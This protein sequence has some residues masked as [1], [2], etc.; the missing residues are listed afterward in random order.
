MAVVKSSNINI[1]DLDFDSVEASLKEYLKGQSTLKDY[2]FEGSNISVLIDLLAYSSHI[3]AFNANMVASEMFL[4]TAQIRKNVV[5]RAKEIG[6]T[7]S[8]KTASKATFDLTVNSPTIAGQTPSTLTI[9]RG[10]RFNTVYDGVTYTFISLDNKTITPDGGQ[11]KFS[12]L[13]VHQGSLTSDIYVYDSQESNQRFSLLNPNVDTSTISVSVNSNNIVTSWT[14]AADLVNVTSS[15]RNYFLQESDEGLYQI[16]FGDGIL[17]AQPKDGDTITISYLVVDSVYANGASTFSMLDSINGNSDVSF[18]NTI[19]SSGGKDGESIDSIKFSANKFYTSQNRL[20]TVADFKA[21]LQELYPGADSIAVWGGEDNDPVAYGR[22]YVSVKPSQFS[23]NLT[24]SEKSVLKTSLKNLS[25][26]TVR[27]EVVDSE[28]LQILLTTNFKFDPTKTSK[29][30]SALETLVKAAIISYDNNNLSG[31]DTI[32]RHS[33]LLGSIDEVEPS[34]LSNIT[35]L[36][37]RR[38]VSA[39]VDGTASGYTVQFGNALYNPHAGHNSS[40]GGILESTAFKVSG[41]T[42]DYQFDDDGNG[43]VRRYYLSGSTRIYKDNNAGTITYSSGKV[44]INS[45][46]LASTA[47]T[48]SSIDFTVIPNSNDVISNRN[49][50]LDITASEISVTG[51]ADT[52]ASGETSAGVGYTTT[53]SYS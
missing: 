49:Q 47:N 28:I 39:T 12:A 43:N 24:S 44:T 11:F 34:I 46:T 23:N 3:S 15:S 26:L 16:Y 19:S 37:L 7:P 13:D 4:D 30:Q 17:G 6:Y 53:S 35:T 38:N 40:S 42:N 31:F 9:T 20:V 36:K 41:D 18:T 45:L 32:F 21:K 50:L 29:S 14:K 10:H 25:M 5:S 2:D 48:D 52:V 8:S 1:T 22:V 33:Q 51:V 27:P